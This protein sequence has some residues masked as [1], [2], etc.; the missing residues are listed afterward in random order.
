LLCVGTL[1]GGGDRDEALGK[2]FHL[3]AMAHPANLPLLDSLKQGDS[4]LYGELCKPV[5]AG[6]A[7]RYLSS[8]FVRYQL[9]AITKAKNGCSTVQDRLIK[10]WSSVLV[11][12][13]RTAA[14]HYSRAA[15][16]IF[17]CDVGRN[18]LGRDRHLP[19]RPSDVLYV[20]SAVVKDGYLHVL[21]LARP[22]DSIIY[23]LRRDDPW[24]LT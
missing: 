12:A 8:Q 9:V 24:R 20:L 2:G 3:V 16:Q 15:P 11:N 6:P 23:S 22:A 10:V 1:G 17:H 4:P 7:P 19:E 14:E 5:L 21:P 13:V 18:Y